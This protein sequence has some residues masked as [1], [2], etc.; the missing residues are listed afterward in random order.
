VNAARPASSLAGGPQGSASIRSSVQG[1]VP[2]GPS[3]TAQD[4]GGEEG[5]A[6]SGWLGFEDSAFPAAAWSQDSGPAVQPLPEP[7]TPP[8]TVQLAS[9]AESLPESPLK[10]EAPAPVVEQAAASAQPATALYAFQAE[11]EGELSVEPGDVLEVL[12]PGGDGW[13]SVVRASDGATGLVPE[14]YVQLQ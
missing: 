11:A 10:Q 7:L 8:S 14:G 13:L 6:P 3:W 12:A 1:G 9:L 4:A 2:P 5:T